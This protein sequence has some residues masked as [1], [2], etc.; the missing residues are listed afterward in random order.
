MTNLFSHSS[1][2]QNSKMGPQGWV[3][4]GGF[5]GESVSLHFL[6]PKIRLHSLLHVH[7]SILE[8]ISTELSRLQTSV[9]L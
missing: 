8:A 2:G 4:S 3:S 9:S 5:R 6:A 1:G 7:S